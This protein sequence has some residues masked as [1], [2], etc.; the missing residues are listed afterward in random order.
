MASAEWWKAVPAWIAAGGPQKSRRQ[1]S[2]FRQFCGAN[3]FGNVGEGFHVAYAL[4]ECMAAW[5]TA[6]EIER[7]G[8]VDDETWRALRMAY[9]EGRLA[10][11]VARA[12]K[13]AQAARQFAAEA[14]TRQW[15]LIAGE[16]SRIIASGS[17]DEVRD[18]YRGST[19]PDREVAAVIVSSDGGDRREFQVQGPRLVQRGHGTAFVHEV[20]QW[21][22][23]R[24]DA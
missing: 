5:E 23:E 21:P 3:G 22:D 6:N 11:Q 17:L 7:S 2:Q 4:D 24:D 15:T 18:A 13:A 10:A 16:Q 9:R 12:E 19:I 14:K 8:V 20:D 1:L